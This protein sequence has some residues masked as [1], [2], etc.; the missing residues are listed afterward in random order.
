MLTQPV[1]CTSRTCRTNQNASAPQRSAWPMISSARWW[2]ALAARGPRWVKPSTS[3]DSKKTFGYLYKSEPLHLWFYSG[4]LSRTTET[5]SGS[6]GR[7]GS[8]RRPLDNANT[9]KP[10]APQNSA[11]TVWAKDVSSLKSK[12]P[13]RGQLKEVGCRQA[14]NKPPI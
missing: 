13:I 10:T 2:S 12:P 1:R 8:T 11:S 5:H 4:Q 14:Q 3:I 6:R 7:L 9:K